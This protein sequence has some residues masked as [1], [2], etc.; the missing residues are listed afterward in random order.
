MIA[1]DP[2]LVHMPPLFHLQE[3]TTDKCTPT[4]SFIW[5][6]CKLLQYYLYV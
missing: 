6:I 2:L 4:D 1:N 5:K 3:M